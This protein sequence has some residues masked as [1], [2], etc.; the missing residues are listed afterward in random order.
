MQ[1]IVKHHIAM[2]SRHPVKTDFK[3]ERRIMC[4]VK[5]LMSTCDQRSRVNNLLNKLK[6]KCK[7]DLF[8]R[9]FRENHENSTRSVG[10]LMNLYI[11][12][13]LIKFLFI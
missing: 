2:T 1:T 12:M 4:I 3:T 5:A 8:R 7:S 6:D 10:K 11:R 9:Y 13:N